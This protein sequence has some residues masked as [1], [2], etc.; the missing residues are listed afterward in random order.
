MFHHDERD[1]NFAVSQAAKAMKD[2]LHSQIQEAKKKSLLA[3]ERVQNE[4]PT[5]RVVRAKSIEFA[6]SGDKFQM[7]IRAA[8]GQIIENA[9]HPWALGQIAEYARIP[10]TYLMQLQALQQKDDCWGANLAAKNLNELFHHLPNEERRLLRT[11]DTETR[12]FLSTKYKRRHP[13]QLLDGFLA[14]CKKNDLIPYTATATDTKHMVRAVLDGII[15]PV[16]NECLGVGV[17]YSESPYGNGSTSVS[18]FIERMWC[19]NQAVMSTDLRSAHL[20]GRLSEDF[21]WS[22][23][24]YLADTKA[25]MYQIQDMLEAYVSKRALDKMSAT[26]K[27]AHD[28]KV[29]SKQFEAFIK[30]NLSKDDAEAVADIYRGADVEM[31]PAG[32]TVWRASNAMSFFAGSV[33]DEEKKF[34]LQK[35]AGMLLEPMS[36]AVEKRKTA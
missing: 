19:T 31:L 33:K 29:E 12:G 20:G 27:L 32:N 34:E 11:V 1:Y 14:A 35:L 23:E 5:D 28:T 36:K 25:T 26:V 15:E 24:T 18:I 7:E 16:P 13:G 10:K 22:E 2:K 8:D 21:E 17:V 4:L 3:L 9:V 30:K 6:N